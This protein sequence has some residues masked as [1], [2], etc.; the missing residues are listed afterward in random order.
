MAMTVES[1]ERPPGL[2]HSRRGF[3][4]NY[5]T[6]ALS[7]IGS[8]LETVIRKRRKLDIEQWW[9]TVHCNLLAATAWLTVCGEV[10]L[11]ACQEGRYFDMDV[12][13]ESRMGCQAAAGA[14]DHTKK[15]RR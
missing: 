6:K 4:T 11:I 7:S 10:I 15:Q 14:M 2:Y 12:T 3:K 13:E 8:A 1:H 5:Y 9:I